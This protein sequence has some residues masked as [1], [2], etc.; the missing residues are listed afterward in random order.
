M[1]F[2]SLLFEEERCPIE[3]GGGIH[4]QLTI[5]LNYK[6]EKLKLANVL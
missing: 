2:S 6:N 4:F 3:R 1:I 5:T